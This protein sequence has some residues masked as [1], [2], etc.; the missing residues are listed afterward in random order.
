MKKITMIIVATAALTLA[1][2]GS[3]NA[4]PDKA[5][6]VCPEVTLGS[7]AALDKKVGYAVSVT[8]S[9]ITVELSDGIRPSSKVEM[10]YVLDANDQAVITSAR[11]AA[12]GKP[13]YPMSAAAML[14]ILGK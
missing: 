10:T 8:S 9:T 11:N 1:A 5:L 13:E 14:C 3:S 6:Q 2:C 12:T 4:N 7:V